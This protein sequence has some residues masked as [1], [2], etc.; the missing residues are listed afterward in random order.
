MI[1]QQDRIQ[2][3]AS[4]LAANDFPPVCAMTGRPAETWRRFNFAT[5]PTWAY[6]L[7]ILVCLGGIGIVLYAVVISL[8]AERAKGFLPLTRASSQRLTIYVWAVIALFLLSIA[9]FVVGIIVSSNDSSG[10]A[11]GLLI[12]GGTFML[13]VTLIALAIRP[14]LGPMA[15]VSPA[16]PGQTDKIVELRHVH[17]NFVAAVQQQHAARAAQGNQPA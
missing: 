7:L 3:W 2:I 14:R 13:L 5:P 16:Q 17:P 1:A 6:A 4:Q 9:L 10:A 12:V 11:G 15:R 8:I